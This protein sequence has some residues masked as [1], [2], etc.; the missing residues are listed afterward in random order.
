[1][2]DKI[3]LRFVEYSSI[4][5]DA[6]AAFQND[7]WCTH[8]ESVTPWNTWL[9]SQA[10]AGVLDRAVNY[11]ATSKIIKV[12]YVTLTDATPDQ[13]TKFYEFMKEQIGK[14]YD[15]D[16]IV[17]LV[18]G[19][20]DWRAGNKWFCSE[21]IAAALERAGYWKLASDTDHLDPRDIYLVISGRL[22]FPGK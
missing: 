2:T 19:T 4:E 9:G 20:R 11:D 3:V 5:A 10:P 13:V 17:H 22:N 8:V 12:Q 7:G 21:L 16:G 15:Y 6:I 1:M 14:P 18:L